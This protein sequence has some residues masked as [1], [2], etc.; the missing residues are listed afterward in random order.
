MKLRDTPTD[1]VFVG[2][3]LTAGEHAT[4]L[5]QT[6]VARIRAACFS[7]VVQ[8]RVIGRPGA[9]VSDLA[10]LRISP[11]RSIAVIEAGTNDW[12]GYMGTRPRRQT[13]LDEF[14]DGYRHV[15]HKALS[16]DGR[17]RPICLGIWG[18][19]EP[20]GGIVSRLDY[21]EAIAAECLRAD[22]VFV[23]L[24]GVFSDPAC[25]GPAGRPTVFGVS[26]AAHPNDLGHA[27]IAS[28]VSAAILGCGAEGLIEEQGRR[29]LDA[30]GVQLLEPAD[31]AAH[32]RLATG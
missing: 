20:S 30:A 12:L 6:F 32:G 23:S 25:R 26:D 7:P 21:D 13:P 18:P 15:L 10:R 17:A 5:D 28:E 31:T 4:D 1:V 9:R 14:R 29:S 2:N 16:L 19:Y 24:G 27:R 8:V 22:G 3:S 11:A